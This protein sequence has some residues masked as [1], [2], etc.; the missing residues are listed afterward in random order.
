MFYF[1]A[2]LV[3]LALIYGFVLWLSR[4]EIHNLTPALKVLLPAAIFGFAIAS[5]II[6]RPVLGA[7]AA[8][9]S[10]AMIWRSKRASDARI[11]KTPA[12]MRSPWLE[13]NIGPERS[14]M[15]GVVLA[16]KSEGRALS[17]LDPDELV[18]LH[19]SLKGDRESRELL[20]AYLDGH[21]PAWRDNPQFDIDGGQ[22][23]S[24]RTG[25]MADEEAYQILGLEAGASAADIRK[26]HRRLSQRMRSN[27]GSLLL[28]SRIDEARDI[29]LAR[30]H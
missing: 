24:P 28:L 17:S 10:A 12:V 19:R 11:L 6:G 5:A 30:H 14:G 27:A 8:F 13:V 7:I 18:N 2:I 21:A 3:S 23:T 25:A 22:G 16:G 4:V 9:V 20:E 15:D 1:L 29:L 26:A